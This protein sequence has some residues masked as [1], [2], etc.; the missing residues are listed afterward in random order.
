VSTPVS[1][2]VAT[3]TCG[4]GTTW[5]AAYPDEAELLECPDC[6]G[7]LPAPPPAAPLEGEEP[8]EGVRP[9]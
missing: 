1:W 3:V 2:L 7:M 8:G 5:V 4:C 9:S 6:H